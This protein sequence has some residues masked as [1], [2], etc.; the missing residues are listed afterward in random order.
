VLAECEVPTAVALIVA[1][2]SPPPV[3]VPFTHVAIRFERCAMH[4]FTRSRLPTCMRPRH[5]SAVA[6]TYAVATHAPQSRSPHCVMIEFRYLA[7][8]TS[9]HH[10]SF[11]DNLTHCHPPT[12]HSSLVHMH[13][14]PSL[15]H[16]PIHPHT[17]P[18]SSIQLT[19]PRP[20][21]SLAASPIQLV[22]LTRGRTSPRHSPP[23]PPRPS[24]SH[25]P[26]ITSSHLLTSLC[27]REGPSA[28]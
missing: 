28:R 2:T 16:T 17:H 9:H 12:T 6:G 22:S 23:T 26:H 13:S 18:T 7:E 15:A 27:S 21:L 4:T 1:C 5:A 14:N 19:Q 24:S 25:P 11:H 8:M 10:F 3:S 20:T